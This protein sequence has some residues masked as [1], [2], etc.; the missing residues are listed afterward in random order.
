MVENI[1]VL[2]SHFKSFHQSI[3]ASPNCKIFRPPVLPQMGFTYWPRWYKWWTQGIPQVWHQRYHQGISNLTHL[4]GYIKYCV[5]WFTDKNEPNQIHLQKITYIF[6]A[7][8]W[9][10]HQRANGTRTT[11][12]RKLN[13]QQRWTDIFRFSHF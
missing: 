13:K 9:R 3:E 7:M 12:R 2:G 5:S 4:A 10:F 6:R 8:L 11:S 1:V